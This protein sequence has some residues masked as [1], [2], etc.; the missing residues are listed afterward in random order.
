MINMQNMMSCKSIFLKS[1]FITLLFLGTGYQIKY[2]VDT[3]WTFEVGFEY[4][5]FDMFSRNGRPIIAFIYWLFS[6]TNLQNEWFYY[7]SYALAFICA[8]ISIVVYTEV[9]G[10]YIK[11]ENLRILLS[12]L[13]IINL[14]SIEYFMFVEEGGF[15]LG[16][17]FCVS[18]VYFINKYLRTSLPSNIAFALVMVL[19]AVC[20]YQG[21]LPVFFIL[22]IPCICKNSDSMMDYI[23]KGLILCF[24]YLVSAGIYVIIYKLF[25][26]GARSATGNTLIERIKY[27]MYVIKH[28]YT[29]TANLLPKY[30]YMCIGLVIL[31][32]SVFGITKLKDRGKAILNV[33]I[34]IVAN[35]VLPVASLIV[36]SGWEAPRIIYPIMSLAGVL[37]VN[38]FINIC[39]CSEEID[40][41]RLPKYVV[42]FVCLILLFS[43]Y[44]S[45]TR[46][47]NDKYKM[48]YADM[49]R[50]QE[51]GQTIKEYEAETGNKIVQFIFYY[52]AHQD[53]PYYQGL[54]SEGDLVV[55]SFHSWDSQLNA[56]NY[57][58]GTDYQRLLQQDDTYKE[59]FSQLDWK[60]YSPSQIRC[61]YDTVHYCVY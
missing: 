38:Y 54:Y 1:F 33:V 12:F 58:L 17:L 18:A 36:S 53:N 42:T 48:N 2:A 14:Y 24:I 43:Q 22:S 13:S 40:N 59:Y 55:S 51:I 50:V 34:I 26:D 61:D 19:L 15:L 27:A 21:V 6:L 39:D 60:C 46:I 35:S 8:M 52:D 44:L 25:C 10:Y 32:F 5:A 31:V 41:N 23:K 28:S 56:I 37:G 30:L 3:F 29:T 20:T 45:F 57:Y 11:N 47:Y 4:M 7:F 49:V 16:I 9:L